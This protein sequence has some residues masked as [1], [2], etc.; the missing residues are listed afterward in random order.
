MT[1]ASEWASRLEA[2]RASGKNATDFCAEH[3]YSAKN[4]VWWSSHLRRKGTPTPKKR[5]RLTLARLVRKPMERR[6]GSSAIVVQ[7]GDARVEVLAGTDRGALSM[8]FE[9]LFTASR[10]G[11]R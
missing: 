10:G 1:K 4:L 3:G 8:V 7:V 11:R 2:W 5:A 9:A 6:S